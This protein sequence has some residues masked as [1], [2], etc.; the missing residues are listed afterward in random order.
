M[1]ENTISLGFTEYRIRMIGRKEAD[2]ITMFWQRD[3]G[4][5]VS[6]IFTSQEACRHYGNKMPL[7]TDEEWAVH[8]PLS[9]Q[10]NLNQTSVFVETNKTKT[11]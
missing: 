6:P 8:Y 7:I 5:I 9:S 10:G 11:I 3:D 1:I 2:K 4:K